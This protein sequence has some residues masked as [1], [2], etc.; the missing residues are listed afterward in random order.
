MD[1]FGESADPVGTAAVLAEHVPLLE[2][3]VGAFTGAAEAGMGAVGVFLRLRLVLALVRGDH[4]VAGLVVAVVALVAQGDEPG[5]FE[6]GEDVPDSGGGGVMRA[7][8]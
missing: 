6:C 4:L 7:A 3:R 5:F 1:G 8:R 2:L